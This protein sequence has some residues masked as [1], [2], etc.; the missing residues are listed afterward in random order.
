MSPRPC[1][2]CQTTE[3]DNLCGFCRPCLGEISAESRIAQ[4][5]PAQVTDPYVLD[6]IARIFSGPNRVAS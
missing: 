2:R 4:G 3:V 6:E 5:L 1:T